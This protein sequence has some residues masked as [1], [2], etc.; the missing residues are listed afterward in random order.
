MRAARL[1]EL[2]EMVARLSA[3]ASEIPPGQEHHNALREIARF[4]AQ[5]VALKS[6]GKSSQSRH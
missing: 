4:R 2:E 5:I 3:T 1:R 6:D